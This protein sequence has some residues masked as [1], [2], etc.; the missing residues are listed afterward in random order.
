[1]T[2]M[3]EVFSLEISRASVITFLS[4][5]DLFFNIALGMI[6]DF[7]NLLLARKPKKIK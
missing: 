3:V 5:I 6:H 7:I 2:H 1:M 4:Y